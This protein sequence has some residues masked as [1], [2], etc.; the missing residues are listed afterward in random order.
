VHQLDQAKEYMRRAL[1]M[2]A[3]DA[4]QQ[5]KDEYYGKLMTEMES[6]YRIAQIASNDHVPKE[7]LHMYKRISSM[8]L[9]LQ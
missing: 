3:T 7:I 8:R 9:T 2:Y 1:E 6:T 5:K 4:P